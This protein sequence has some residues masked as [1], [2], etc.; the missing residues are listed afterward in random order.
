[1]KSLAGP[2]NSLSGKEASKITETGIP[3]LPSALHFGCF[4]FIFFFLFDSVD[5]FFFFFF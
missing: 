5:T 2:F 4:S 1:M 3:S